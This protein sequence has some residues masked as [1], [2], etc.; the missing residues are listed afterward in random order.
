[1]I[2]NEDTEFS[3]RLLACGELLCYE[4]SAVVRHAIPD[5]RLT[6]KYFLTFWY[7]YGRA[8]V[9]ESAS[10]SDVFGIPRWCFSVPLIVA[11]VL[12]VRVRLW[13]FER[14]A[15]RRFFFKCTVWRTFGELAELP[16]IR[17][18]PETGRIETI[19][20]RSRLNETSVF[21]R[22]ENSSPIKN[23]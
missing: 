14:D 10:R 11:N 9:R 1:M 8:S 12:P 6:E 16:R 22:E 17:K 21:L 20:P 5:S 18:H 2:G 19:E 13:L 3:N 4:P 15:K 7:N 23:I